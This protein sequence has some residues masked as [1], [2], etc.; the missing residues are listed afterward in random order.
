MGLGQ[1]AG[2]KMGHLGTSVGRAAP[3]A[4][5]TGAGAGEPASIRGAGSAE[6]RGFR[7][8]SDVKLLGSER[9]ELISS[10]TMYFLLRS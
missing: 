2:T 8:A 5:S 1:W 4:V 3:Q 7:A 6:K 9:F 10:S